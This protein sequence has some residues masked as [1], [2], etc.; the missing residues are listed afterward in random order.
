MAFKHAQLGGQY[1]P[2]ICEAIYEGTHKPQV[3]GSDWHPTTIPSYEAPFRLQLGKP[4]KGQVITH[5]ITFFLSRHGESKELSF[6]VDLDCVQ[7]GCTVIY[8]NAL[9]EAYW[10]SNAS[11]RWLRWIVRLSDALLKRRIL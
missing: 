2:G 3:A 8:N 7:L 4:H 10:Y 1:K 5:P 11:P 6:D 9:R